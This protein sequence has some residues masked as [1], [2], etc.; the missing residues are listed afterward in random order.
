MMK[1][2]MWKIV[3][4]Q[5]TCLSLDWNK[6]KACSV[7]QRF[8][9]SSSKRNRR[10]MQQVTVAPFFK[11]ENTHKDVTS[12]TPCLKFS[13]SSSPGSSSHSW[14][15]PHPNPSLWHP[16]GIW[17]RKG[18]M[19]SFLTWLFHLGWEV[20]FQNNG[21][22]NLGT[23]SSAGFICL[24]ENEWGS[25]PQRCCKVTSLNNDRGGER[26]SSP[27]Q[28]IWRVDS[29]SKSWALVCPCS[30]CDAADGLWQL[31]NQSWLLFPL[32]A[33]AL[34]FFH[35]TLCADLKAADRFLFFF[36]VMQPGGLF[37]GTLS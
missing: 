30:A 2:K 36:Y 19:S 10:E 14:S 12:P 16:C 25:P 13:G 18:L 15:F 35:T 5:D 34:C 1:Q 11:R 3:Y 26:P 24:L 32:C 20:Q 21:K 33:N 17:P 4:L 29:K 9:E 31:P 37:K 6:L 28:A 23:L 27:A 8:R 22:C 7:K